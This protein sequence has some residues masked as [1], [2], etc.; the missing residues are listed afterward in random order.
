AGSVTAICT[1]F[2][3]GTR[4]SEIWK[5]PSRAAR[6]V[7]DALLA[8][9][10]TITVDPAWVAPLIVAF[11]VFT[12]EPSLGVLIEIFG[13]VR[14]RNQVTIGEWSDS[15]APRNNVAE[16]SLRPSVSVMGTIIRLVVPTGTS[17]SGAASSPSSAS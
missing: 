14:S 3:P 13:G 15:S 11:G 8:G 9:L 4:G 1:W 10:R 6:A 17:T 2:S 7:I 5:P 16:R 12:D